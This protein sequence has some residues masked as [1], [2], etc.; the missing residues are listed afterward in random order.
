MDLGKGSLHGIAA[1]EAANNAASGANPIPLLAFGIP[2]DVAAALI[3]GALLKL[4]I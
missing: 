2:G 4:S 1:P 3:L